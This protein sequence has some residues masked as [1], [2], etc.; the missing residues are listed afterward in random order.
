MVLV[1]V[2]CFQVAAV[3]EQ[4]TQTQST[5]TSSNFAASTNTKHPVEAKSLG[6]RPVGVFPALVQKGVVML[7]PLA[8]AKEGNG[9]RYFSPNYF[10]NSV[11]GNRSEQERNTS[12]EIRLFGWEF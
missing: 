12:G 5:P 2:G 7:S 8:P 3:A 10:P 11:A 6:P 9:E 4:Y 1:L